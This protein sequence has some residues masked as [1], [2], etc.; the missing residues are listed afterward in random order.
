MK[1]V[2]FESGTWWNKPPTSTISDGLLTITTENE[3]DLWRHTSYGFIHDT[4][5]GLLV[6]FPDNSA[7]ECDVDATYEQA[8]DQAGLLVFSSETQ[9]IKCGIEFADGVPQLGAVVTNTVSDWSAGPAPEWGSGPTRFRVSRS[10]DA[11]TIRA[12]RPGGAWQ[13]VRL[14]PLNPDLTWSAGP[15]AASPSRAGLTVT[16]QNWKQGKADASLH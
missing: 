15:Y 9:W 1:P 16:F 11:L 5:H 3:S 13:L 6:P 10:G 4:G 14:A 12:Q 7:M 2:D 8:F